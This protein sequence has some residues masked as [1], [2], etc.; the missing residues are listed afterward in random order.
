V[1]AVQVFLAKKSILR[2]EHP[3]Y[4][5]D[6]ALCDFWLFPKLKATLK[7]H[8]FSDIADI[9]GHATSIQKR[10]SR[11]VLSSGNTKPLSVLV[12][13]ETT[14]KVTITIIV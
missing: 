10:S 2:L 5:P 13:R 3:P 4:L 8:R 6:I 1:L 11:N 7:G 9:Q 14:L 12:R